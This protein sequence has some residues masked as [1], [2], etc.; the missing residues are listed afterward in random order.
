MTKRY[1]LASLSLAAVLLVAAP[2]SQAVMPVVDV[3][4]IAQMLEQIRT[5]QAHLDTARSMLGEAQAS[6]RSMTGPRGME[7]LLAGQVRNYLPSDWLELGS[8]ISSLRGQ[9]GALGNELQSIVGD[10]AVLSAREL[11]GLGP[12]QQ[13]RVTE[14]RQDVA[15]AQGLAREALSAASARFDSL[16]QL[17][18][19]I[20]T[21]DDPKAVMDLQARIAAEQAMLANDHTKLSVLFESVNAEREARAQQRRE[22]AIR[23]IGSLRNLRPMGL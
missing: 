7:R 15:L 8:A 6:F 16:N 23:D 9:Y 3:R 2:A 1:K 14:A 22:R 4:A 17:I 12:Q 11:A 13:A 20:S 19:A 5:L 21:A 10:N 18:A